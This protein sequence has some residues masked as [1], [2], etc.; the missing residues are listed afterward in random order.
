[1]SYIILHNCN[2]AV[3]FKSLTLTYYYHLIHAPFSDFFSCFNNVIYSKR[4]QSKNHILYW[5]F[6]SLAF[7]NLK[8]FLWISLLVMNVTFVKNTGHLF[9]RNVS[10][11]DV[12]S[13]LD[14]AYVVWAK[15]LDMMLCSFHC[16]LLG[17]HNSH[18]FH[19]GWCFDH[20][21]KVVFVRTLLS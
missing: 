18:L 12:K 20:L 1:M 13:W 17:G 2:T 4:I 5:I 21:I 14:S 3:K 9:C 7:F 8:K 11:F 19:Y 10:H 15:I 6:M 16:I